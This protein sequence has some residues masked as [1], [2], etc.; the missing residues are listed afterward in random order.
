MIF[1]PQ[2]LPVPDLEYMEFPSEHSSRSSLSSDSSVL[3]WAFMS[4]SSPSVR[5]RSSAFPGWEKSC[6][7]VYRQCCVSPCGHQRAEPA[8]AQIGWVP[9]IDSAFSERCLLGIPA[10]DIASYTHPVSHSQKLY[11][12]TCLTAVSGAN[13]SFRNFPSPYSPS[14]I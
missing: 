11:L 5:T 14:E 2:T 13:C 12:Y 9:C 10:L 3:L 7:P 4:G 8:L 6:L 1:Q